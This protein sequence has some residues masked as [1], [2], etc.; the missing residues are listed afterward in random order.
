MG[1]HIPI[2]WLG[3]KCHQNFTLLSIRIKIIVSFY[4]EDNDGIMKL[5]II[6]PLPI[7][8]LI[9]LVW[10]INKFF[11]YYCF[12]KTDISEGFILII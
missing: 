3:W 9:L 1:T 12:I 6:Y 10:P 8:I 7:S 4:F 2:T 5:V 11:V